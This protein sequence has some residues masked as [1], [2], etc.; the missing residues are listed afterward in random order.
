MY[1]IIYI[2]ICIC[3]CIYIYT[4]IH[5]Y[6]YIH[7]YTHMYIDALSPPEA[8]RRP[9]ENAESGPEAG[10][11]IYYYYYYI[12]II[13][14]SIIIMCIYI[15]MYILL[16]QAG[17]GENAEKGKPGEANGRTRVSEGYVCVYIYI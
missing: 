12:I 7:I 8:S 11:F 9:G 15:Y 10:K 14:M 1:I 5:I 13:I 6:I 3:M 17:P 16:S 4:H 2:Y